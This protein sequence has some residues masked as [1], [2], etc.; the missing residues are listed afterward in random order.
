MSPTTINEIIDF[1]IAR[2][3]EAVEFYRELQSI[4]RFQE[5]TGLLAE[6]EAM[7]KGHIVILHDLRRQGLKDDD[8]EEKM[9]IGLKIA[10]YLVAAPPAPEMSYQDV[11]IVAMKREQAAVD[12]YRKLADQAVNDQERRIFS[13]L[14][15]EESKH[16]HTFE[17]IYDREILKEN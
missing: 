11:L 14:A 7:E 13:R 16:K 3:E 12:L 5:I 17:E 8:F 2:E 6:L 9:T 15:A 1:A 4:S 10:D